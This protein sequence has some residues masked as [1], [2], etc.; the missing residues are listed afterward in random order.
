[1]A[2]ADDEDDEDED[3]DAGPFLSEGESRALRRAL[4]QRRRALQAQKG[5]LPGRLEEARAALSPGGCRQVVLDI[6]QSVLLVH[7][8][9]AVAA[10]RRQLVA[11]VSNLWEKYRFSMRD[12]Q[13][14]LERSERRMQE[15]M[16]QLGYSA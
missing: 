9:G 14:D 13:A 8:D 3:E 4:A 16:R 7:L 10:Q 2:K 6:L 5:A 11:E 12:I 15:V 1:M